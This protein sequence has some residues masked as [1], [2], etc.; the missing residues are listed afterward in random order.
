MPALDDTIEKYYNPLK[1][2]AV[3]KITV[4]FKGRV[5]FRQYI[6]KKH[7]HFRI[8]IFNICD[9]AGYT[10]NMTV[11]IGK[12]RTHAVQDMTATHATVRD[13]C[14]RTERVG[15]TLYMDN[16]FSSPDLLD[17]P[18][19]KLLWAG[20]TKS[21]R[22]TTRLMQQET[23]TEGGDIRVKVRGDTT[24]LVWKDKRD[25]YGEHAQSSSRRQF[26]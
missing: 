15:H 5:V 2:L 25:V 18:T 16:F 23:W 24:A 10:C 4:K 3:D 17:E 21:E 11:Y 1:H 13:L 7:R 22:L 9:A 20:Q 12:D 19:T 26:L 6:P 14:R 8:K